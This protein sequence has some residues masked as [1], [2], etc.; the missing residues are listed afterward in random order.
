MSWV[1]DKAVITTYLSGLGYIEMKNLIEI[2]DS[3]LSYNHKHYVMKPEGFPSENLTDN[4]VIGTHL[5]RLEI[6]YKNVNTTERD[7]NYD[8]FLTLAKGVS[9]LAGFLGY[10]EATFLDVLEF[11]TIGSLKFHFGVEACS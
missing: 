10:E 2:D 7:A 11:H 6:Q 4:S 9:N 3:P 5:V 1:T 8:D